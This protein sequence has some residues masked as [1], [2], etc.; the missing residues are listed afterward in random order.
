MMSAAADFER[1][2]SDGGGAVL[3]FTGNLS[4]AALGDLPDRLGA[5]EGR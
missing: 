4:L 2:D 1:V 3:R 5:I